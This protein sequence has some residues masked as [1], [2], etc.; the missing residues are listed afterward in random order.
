MQ[1]SDQIR[2]PHI[3]PIVKWP[4][5]P[6]GQEVTDIVVGVLIVGFAQPQVSN[7]SHF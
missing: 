5:L 7:W 3:L 2:A 1:T 4:S 6:I